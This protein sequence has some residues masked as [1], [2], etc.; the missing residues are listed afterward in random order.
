MKRSQYLIFILVILSTVLLNAQTKRALIVAIG[1]YPE[2][3]D[4]SLMWSDLSS[5]NDYNLVKDMLL[6]QEF[7]TE[8]IFSLIDSQATAG[9]LDKKFSELLFKCESGDVI[10]FH[11]SGHGQQVTDTD[12]E[13]HSISDYESDGYD[14]S[15]VMYSAPKECS[16][17]YNLAEH[18]IDDRLNYWITEIRKKIDN[19]HVIM[20][21]DA[22]HSG[23]ASRGN[24]KLDNQSTSLV[25]GT[26]K[27]LAVCD[28][29]SVVNSSYQERDPSLKRGFGIDVLSGE[30]MLSDIVVFSGCRS[31]ETNW[32]C[33]GKSYGSLSYAFVKG[34]KNLS[35]ENSTYDDLYGCINEFVEISIN[36]SAKNIYRHRQHPQIEPYEGRSLKIFNGEF[37]PSEPVY[38]IL[39]NKQ[40]P[41]WEDIRINAGSINS[42][43]RL[44]DK[45][46]FRLVGQ[47]DN[48]KLEGTVFKVDNFS[49]NIYI[50]KPTVKDILS[51][52]QY[53]NFNKLFEC[54]IPYS[55]K[56]QDLSINVD[57]EDYKDKQ[58]ILRMLR[59]SQNLS[60]NKDAKYVIVDSLGAFVIKTSNSNLVIQDMKPSGYDDVYFQEVL[61]SLLEIESIIKN[62]FNSE[63]I[64]VKFNIQKL[65]KRLDR[66]PVNIINDSEKGVFLYIYEISP[67]LKLK[68]LYEGD[69][70]EGDS[71][72][73]KWK[74]DS[75]IGNYIFL[76]IASDQKINLNNLNMLSQV[77]STRGHK[78]PQVDWV[79]HIVTVEE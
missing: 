61:S 45:V 71:I 64:N 58:S 47:K 6:E 20:V 79:R 35:S 40:K 53:N 62:N 32:E 23:T 39:S 69:L 43:I 27:T 65:I 54:V 28:D 41:N 51:K 19:G 30:E 76:V 70:N 4:K 16:E 48:L 9:A 55:F 8:N 66:V 22:C 24:Q 12:Q 18:Y 56:I 5:V 2:Y 36:Q 75:L 67:D 60:Y 52:I 10:Y 78:L 29:I 74:S 11:F 72:S 3:S 21:I 26:N 17:K 31:D 33:P 49:S 73:A 57:V 44:N 13:L 7:N 63:E 14:E 15:L 38:N 59:K 50:D 46:V 34:I 42:N 77:T 1:D 37:I 68:R 25:R